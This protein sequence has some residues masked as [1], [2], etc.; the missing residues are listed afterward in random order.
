[1]TLARTDA[2][3]AHFTAGELNASDPTASPGIVANCRR[4]AEY[5]EV[6]RAALGNRPI[7]VTSGYRS[8]D[9]NASVGGTSTS[10]HQDG[11]AADIV[12]ANGRTMYDNYRALE[13]A[14]LPPFDQ[15]IYYPVQGHIHIGLGSKMRREV[16]IKAYEGP[17]GT[18]LLTA[19]NVTQLPG[20][21]ADVVTS[22][23]TNAAGSVAVAT[24]GTSPLVV[25]G[26]VLLLLTLALA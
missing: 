21:V 8:P 17:G 12:P 20:Y 19:A 18:P 15:I 25:A 14:D 6:V 13:A 10:S 5:L 11:L 16:R 2:L 22:A 9:R 24:G 4:M 1:M 23:V 26:V 3:T 7:R